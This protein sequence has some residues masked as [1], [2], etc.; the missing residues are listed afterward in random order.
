[1]FDF[2]VRQRGDRFE[3]VYARVCMTD[4]APPETGLWWCTAETPSSNLADWKE[5]VQIS[6]A[7]DRGWHKGPWK[8][9]LHYDDAQPDAGFV[10]FDGLYRTDDPGPFPFAFTLGCLKLSSIG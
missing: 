10:F 6:G 5:P 2:C 4:S 7:E 3:A 8:P 9:S 1:M